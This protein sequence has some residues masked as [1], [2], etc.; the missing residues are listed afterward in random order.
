MDVDGRG[1]ED[2]H[3]TAGG[4]PG[5]AAESGSAREGSIRVERL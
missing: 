3:G 4:N 5:R 2:G 1:E